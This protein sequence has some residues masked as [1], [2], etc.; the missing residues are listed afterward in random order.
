MKTTIKKTVECLSRSKGNP[1]C[2]ARL[3]MRDFKGEKTPDGAR[4]SHLAVK[5]ALTDD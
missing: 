4:Y 5:L 2:A 1:S 3:F